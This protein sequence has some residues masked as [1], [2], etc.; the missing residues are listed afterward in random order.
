VGKT[1]LDREFL[2]HLT[3]VFNQVVATNE[4]DKA[5]LQKK[6]KILLRFYNVL[7][8]YRRRKETYS[9][10]EWAA[11]FIELFREAMKVLGG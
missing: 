3:Y 7:S 6:G 9:A 5:T 1:S 10:S 8:Q 11:K 4:W 2:E